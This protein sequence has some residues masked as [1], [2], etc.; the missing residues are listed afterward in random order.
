[1]KTSFAASLL[2]ISITLTLFNMKARS[3]QPIKTY[4]KEWKK[5]DDFVKKELPKSALAEVKK[6]YALAKKDGSAGSPQ[7]AQIIKS[8]VYMT[9][10][11]NDTRENNEIASIKEIEKEIAGSKEPAA[12]ILSSLLAD[13]YWNY[14]SNR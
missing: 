14:Y 11:Q 2:F 6:I 1:M 5:V 4:A 3:Q 8:L 12:S 13:M 10:L 9:G 7:D